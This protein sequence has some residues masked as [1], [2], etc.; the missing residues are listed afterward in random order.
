MFLT[1]AIGEMPPS[2]VFPGMKKPTLLLLAA[3]LWVAISAH[4]PE[5][6]AVPKKLQDH[7][8][9]V[10][11]VPPGDPGNA[12]WIYVDYHA[13][14]AHAAHGDTLFVDQ[15]SPDWDEC[16]AGGDAGPFEPPA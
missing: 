10:C 16:G 13:V 8:V 5:A 6:K 15:G 7:K 14:R 9:W 1:A 12:H 4:A 11:H 2:K 3:A